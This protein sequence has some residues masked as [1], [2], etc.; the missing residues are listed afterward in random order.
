MSW[1]NSTANDPSVS[2]FMAEINRLQRE[3]DRANESIDDKI[4]KLE[5]AGMGV[6]G[7]TQ[8]LEDAR[9]KVVVLEV[10][11]VRHKK[12]EERRIRRLERLRCQKCKM[13]VD[14]RHILHDE[15][16]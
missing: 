1:L 8:K 12:A 15:D 14:I 9:A 10:E 13:R 5:D 16:R 7:L 3:L 2:H 11:I 4:D 6:I